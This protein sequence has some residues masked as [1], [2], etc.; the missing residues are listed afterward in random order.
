MVILFFILTLQLGISVAADGTDGTH[1]NKNVVL[2]TFLAA[3]I[4]NGTRHVKK[5]HVKKIVPNLLGL[6]LANANNANHVFGVDQGDKTKA[7]YNNNRRMTPSGSF[8]GQCQYP[9]STTHR[10]ERQCLF[11]VSS[12]EVTVEDKDR[13]SQSRRS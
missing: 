13:S 7:H 8:S 9:T 4:A 3:N 1:V 12:V 10:F 11:R 6:N 2:D 5:A